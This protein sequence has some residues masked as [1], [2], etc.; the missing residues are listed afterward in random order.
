MAQINQNGILFGNVSL[1]GIKIGTKVLSGEYILDDNRN[2]INNLPVINAI[3][4]DWNN[5]TLEDGT[6]F[7]TTGEVL[8][9]VQSLKNNYDSLLQQYNQLVEEL[10]QRNQTIAT[11][12]NELNNRLD[13]IDAISYDDP[14]LK[15]FINN[16]IYEYLK[17]NINKLLFVGTE[18]PSSIDENNSIIINDLNEIRIYKENEISTKWYFVIP[19]TY[20]YEIYDDQMLQRQDVFY[21]EIDSNYLGQYRLYESLTEDSSISIILKKINN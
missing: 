3:D 4:I 14:Q 5:S 8:S 11:S 20:S 12:I 2:I 1:S 15:E 10:E 13:N 17:T 18:I 9:Y 6:V 19:N 16:A 7:K 21:N